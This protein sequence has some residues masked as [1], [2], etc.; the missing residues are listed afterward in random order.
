MQKSTHLIGCLGFT[1]KIELAY[2]CYT[3]VPFFLWLLPWVLVCFHLLRP[4]II[5]IGVLGVLGVVGIR[6]DRRPKR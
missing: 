6:L 2:T 3:K 5:T 4:I 1:G